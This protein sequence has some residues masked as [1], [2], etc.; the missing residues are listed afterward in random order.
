ML[1]SGRDLWPTVIN[2][3]PTTILLAMSC[4][5]AVLST[6]VLVSGL[7]PDIRHIGGSGDWLNFG[8]SGINLVLAAVG[9][10]YLI[11][12]E[13]KGDTIWGW[14][15]KNFAVDHPDVQFR[16]VCG[17]LNFVFALGWG[18]VS[19]ETLILVNVVVGRLV[20]RRGFLRGGVPRVKWRPGA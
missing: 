12:G 9:T 13:G 10:G 1:Y 17:E 7:K 18:I 6:I 5:T 15:C 4:V 3:H 16:L 19:A 2:L 8:V 20:V 11:G 14:T